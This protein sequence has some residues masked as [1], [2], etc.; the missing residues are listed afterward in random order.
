MRA[1]AKEHSFIGRHRQLACTVALAVLLAGCGGGSGDDQAGH[2][3]YHGSASGQ[4]VGMGSA[5]GVERAT[6]GG[7][8]QSAQ[9]LKSWTLSNPADISR[10]LAQASFGARPRDLKNMLNTT[11]N[12]WIESEFAKPQT[13]LLGIVDTWKATGKI[14][15]IT[16]DD[17]HNAWWFST[18]Q[19]DQLRQRVAFALSQIFVVS[20]NAAPGNYP[21]GMAAYYDILSRNAFGNFRQ[22]LED[23]TL[24]PMMGLYLTHIQNR[25]EQ[26]DSAGEQLT[27]PDENYARE[28][29]QLFT[30]GLE[31][32]NQDG[33]PILDSKGE[34]IPTYGNEDVIGLARVFTGWSWAGPKDSADCFWKAR[35]CG[36]G[37]QANREVLPMRA[38]P[39]FHSVQDKNFL[40][41]RITGGCEKIKDNLE[42]ALDTLFNHPNVGPFIGKQLIQRLVVSNPSPAYVQRVAAAFNNNG[43]GVRGDMKA[44]IRAILLDPEARERRTSDKN[45]GR[46]REPVLRFAHLMRAFEVK[47]LNGFHNNLG[48]TSLSNSLNQTAMRSPS[49]F[50]FYRPGYSP[51]NT[52]VSQAGLVAPELAITNESSIAGYASFLDQFVGGTSISSIG[53]GRII[54]VPD[55]T[56]TSKT[57]RRRMMQFDYSPML[58]LVRQPE[59]LV[60]YVDQLLLGGNMQADT[61]RVITKAITDIKYEY[62]PKTPER[63]DWSRASLAIYLALMST[64]YMVQK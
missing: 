5:S 8:A 47:S 59:Q 39:Q 44:V 42:I 61:R 16:I 58:A 22:L 53:L 7:S 2:S 20:S 54:Y 43:N 40:G 56:D 24:S 25:R 37:A 57:L 46:M 45:A 29:M 52:P 14:Q 34:P 4:F 23:V 11:A 36:D 32:L 9:S 51:S 26:F 13:S 18:I 15:S 60:N 17:T 1:K 41:V 6:T 49:V 62:F 48:Q 35:T 50:N 3:G 27:S 31:M 33:T 63:V 30:I 55:P 38:Y 12:A 64:D 19:D 10:F 28:V 21:R